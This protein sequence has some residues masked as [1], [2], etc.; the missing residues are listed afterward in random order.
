MFSLLKIHTNKNIFITEVYAS[1]FQ[2]KG[3]KRKGG[4]FNKRSDGSFSD[5]SNSFIRQV[6]YFY[7]FLKLLLYN[8]QS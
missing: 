3:G 5:S 2:G 6:S 7:E 1:F 8:N 4:K